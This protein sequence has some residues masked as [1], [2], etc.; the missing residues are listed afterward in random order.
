VKQAAVRKLSPSTPDPPAP[1]NRA[2]VPG[3][4]EIPS[5]EAV[6]RHFGANPVI[7]ELALAP[8]SSPG[9][10]LALVVPAAEE[11]RRRNVVA[12]W[13]RLR[14]DLEKPNCTWSQGHVRLD[15]LV[16]SFD[17]LPRRSDASVDRAAV[18]KVIDRELARRAA[19][20]QSD[21]W[22]ELLEDDRCRL[23]L[24]RL[25]VIG[26][27]CCEPHPGLELERDLGLDSLDQVELRLL[28]E[29]EFGVRIADAEHWAQLTVA[30]LMRRIRDAD[31]PARPGAANLGW[32]RRLREPPR[33]TLDR[34]FIDRRRLKER[35][36]RFFGYWGV[37]LYARLCH[38]FRVLGAENLPKSGGYLL[39][40]THQSLIDGPLVW[41]ALDRATAMR[42][43]SLVFGEYFH[44]GP[45]AAGVVG[46][47]LILTGEADSVAD[48][49]RV[50]FDALTRG[51]VVSVFP[52]GD[53]SWTGTI[54]RPRPGVGMLACEA[55]VPVV[56]AIFQGSRVLLS[57]AV[58][59][60]H[61]GPIR[62][63]VGDPIP[64]P[65]PRRFCKRD[66][67]RHLEKWSDAVRDLEARFGG[68]DGPAGG[69]R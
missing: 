26:D 5:L 22:D 51:M 4:A 36:I 9:R 59:G 37:R 58:S 34:R 18:A 30:D 25:H 3:A 52:E 15:E 49:M 13:S 66:Y 45:L 39:C 17:P 28:L 8:T 50:A 33:E 69:A 21:E 12:L 10:Y 14:E 42:T 46:G 27:L 64:P 40:P 41:A 43:A 61:P 11:L 16:V 32:D 19:V 60:L 7:A 31:A 38:R 6:E 47:Q 54:Q 1:M 57:H 53:R 62:M 55:Q 65:A 68:R 24:D 63:V 48:S 29:Q 44:E 23:L 56:P 35:A 67:V 20:R 2:R